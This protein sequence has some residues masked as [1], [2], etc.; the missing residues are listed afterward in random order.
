ML[1]ELFT[2]IANNTILDWLAFL[3]GV[4]QVVLA[5]KNKRI[6]FVAGIIS[7]ALYVYIFY[8]AGLFAES[9]LNFYYLIVSIWGLIAW[10]QNTR[11]NTISQCTKND[12]IIA[13]VIFASASILQF[14]ILKNYT[15]STVPLAD[16]LVSSMAWAGTWLLAKRKVQ[17]WVLLNISNA[18]AIPLFIYKQL[19]LVAILY[20]VFFIIAIFGYK[21]WQKEAQ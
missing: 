1:Q 4:A 16:S 3:F 6:N 2:Q 18:F 15:T 14:V 8:K 21:Q 10:Q 13:F 11:T 9:F 7:V 20:V 12:Y 19:Y 5:L 17:N